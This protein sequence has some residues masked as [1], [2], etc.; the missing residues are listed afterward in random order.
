MV[1]LENCRVVG[2]VGLD[3]GGISNGGSKRYCCIR[4]KLLDSSLFLHSN[5]I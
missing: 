3:V 5:W 2:G 4:R 1:R